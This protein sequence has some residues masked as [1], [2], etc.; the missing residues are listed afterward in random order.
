M[1]SSAE[2]SLAPTPALVD[3]VQKWKYG[4]NI[5][6]ATK[7]NLNTYTEAKLKEYQMDNRQDFD[8]WELFQ[9]HF[10]DYTKDYFNAIRT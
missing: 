10:E 9:E 4:I 8:L 6:K 3:F 7:D 1:D 2:G 5:T